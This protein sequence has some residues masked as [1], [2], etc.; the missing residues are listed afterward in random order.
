M[1]LTFTTAGVKQQF[2]VYEREAHFTEQRSIAENGTVAAYRL[3]VWHCKTPLITRTKNDRRWLV[4]GS[5]M[6]AR[7]RT[8]SPLG[9]ALEALQLKAS[10]SETSASPAA[11]E[12]PPPSSS[13]PERQSGDS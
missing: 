10:A 7:S 5:F 2:I 8:P 12:A 13:A 11:S 3:P 6:L 1:H 9:A 4:L